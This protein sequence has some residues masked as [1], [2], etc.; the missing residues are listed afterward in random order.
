MRAR[1]GGDYVMCRKIIFEKVIMGEGRV[2][3][4]WGW[5]A[6]VLMDTGYQVKQILVKPGQRLSYQAHAQR[7]ERWIVVCGRA[8]V[9]LN[10]CITT[11][12][13]GSV[14][15]IDVGM[16]HRLVN[17]E[18]TDLVI[19]EVQLGTYLGEDDIIRFQDDYGRVV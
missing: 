5:Y 3:R 4:P 11:H 7:S 12:E 9:V 16:K 18:T 19:I 10:D 6:T 2:E 8:T 15:C 13:L 14:I 17:H 1:K